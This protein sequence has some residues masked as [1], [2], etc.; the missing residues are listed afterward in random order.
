MPITITEVSDDLVE[1]RMTGK[2]HKDDYD[3]FV[4]AVEAAIE[5]TGKIRFLIIMEDF[6]GWDMAAVWEDTKFDMKHHADIS[7]LAMVGDKKWEEWMATFCRPFVGPPSS[8]SMF[9]T[10]RPPAPGSTS[11][12]IH[13][14]GA[15][16][17]RRR[18]A[19]VTAA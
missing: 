5:R 10:P 2:L 9:P 12:A 6:H 14:S 11:R 13:G 7:R 4:P 17:T 15:R 8:T 3:E 1:V 16:A 18:A 19:G